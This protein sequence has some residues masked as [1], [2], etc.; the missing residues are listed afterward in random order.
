MERGLGYLALGPADAASSFLGSAPQEDVPGLWVTTQET[1][2]PPAGVE[3]LRVTTLSG[4]PGTVDPKRLAELR[5]AV[6]LFLDGHP[7]SLAVL[8]CL[9]YLVVH[10]GVERVERTLADLH[11]DVAM[12]RGTLVVFA[13]PRIANRRLLAWLEREFDG[14]PAVSVPIPEADLPWTTSHAPK[15]SPIPEAASSSWDRKAR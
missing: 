11:D 15:T 2:R 14:L 8:D 9:E 6:V 13:D 10:N 7:D 12:R 3:L 5:A 4:R 1:L